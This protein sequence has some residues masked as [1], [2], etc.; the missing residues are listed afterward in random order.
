[1]EI[2]FGR[3]SYEEVYEFLK[4]TDKE[5]DVPLSEKVNLSDYASKLSKLSSF[6]YCIDNGHIVAM[7]S[8]YVNCP[9]VGYISNVCIMNQYQGC[10]L[11]TKLLS[12]LKIESRQLGITYFRLEVNIDNINARHVYEHVG[13]DYESQSV[14]GGSYYMFLYNSPL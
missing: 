7:I 3:L 10:G 9:P 2:V 12:K 4:A 14:N 8:C 13:F 1:M 5:F 11:F 6:S